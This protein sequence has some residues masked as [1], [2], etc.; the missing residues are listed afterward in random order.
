MTLGHVLITGGSA[1]IGRASVE[2]CLADEYEPVVIDREGERCI[3]AD[4]SNPSATAAAP[5]K[6]LQQGPITRLRAC[7]INQATGF[8]P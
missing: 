4:L 2:R 5:D 1:G 8:G 7:H 3:H 6:A